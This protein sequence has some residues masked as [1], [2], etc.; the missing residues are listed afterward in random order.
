LLI[1]L[2]VIALAGCTSSNHV[3]HINGNTW[4][5]T[6]HIAYVSAGGAERELGRA[7][8]GL[9]ADINQSLSV[10]IDTSIISQIN[11]SSDTTV[12]HPVDVHFANV[13]RRS[14]DVYKDTG[15]AFNPAVGP[16]VDA[17]GFGFDGSQG[18]PDDGTIQKLLVLASF[19]VFE[20][21]DSPPAVR[22]RLPDA[23][24]DFN[25]IAE[26]Y[27]ADEI[28]ELLEQRG[29]KNYVVEL[30]GEV[31][32]RGKR[33]DGRGWQVGIEKPQ[34]SPD[35]AR[36][37]QTLV[38]LNDSGM[39]TSG[40][41]RKRR[42]QDGKVSAHILDPKTGRP[43]L[44]SVISVSVLAADAATA[45]GYATALV[46][47]GLDE[48]LRFVEAR[49]GLQAYFIAKDDAGNTIEKRSSGFPPPSEDVER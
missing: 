1:A 9:L 14:L 27:A 24:L 30:G 13:F 47:M 40:N 45:D 16:L 48:G 28:G 15:G 41:F 35:A 26:G 5:T 18:I 44:N 12:W 31:R 38:S 3:E 17:W 20:L 43:A 34:S 22:K 29:V 37:I 46:V 23:R 2:A 42:V 7:I 10:Y 32:A 11:A 6:Y 49:K 39:S 33:P 19:D 25:A 8:E 36:E 21:K 4:G